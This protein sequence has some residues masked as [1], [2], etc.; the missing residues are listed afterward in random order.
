MGLVGT[1]F[2]AAT[3]AAGMMAEGKAEKRR[4]AIEGQWNERRAL[5]ERASAQSEAAQELRAKNLAQSRLGAIAG[6][7][8]SGASDP[9]VMNLWK[10]IEG[11]G[12]HNAD[13]AMAGG[14]QRV[15]GLQYQT[16]LDRW[17]ASTNARIK[18]AGA[19]NTIIGGLIGAGG[20]AMKTRMSLRY[21]GGRSYGGTGYGN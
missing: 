14:N 11:E 7:S 17:T 18:N 4:A 16:A 19:R 15:A 10:G 12:R 5:E 1:M 2:S 13:M 21:G 3:G 9:T 6:A 20:N 8:G